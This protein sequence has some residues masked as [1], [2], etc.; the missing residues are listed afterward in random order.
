MA[1]KNLSKWASKTFW[2][3]EIVVEYK[4]A[5]ACQTARKQTRAQRSYPEKNIK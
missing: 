3:L 5:L 2:I 4:K 1:F